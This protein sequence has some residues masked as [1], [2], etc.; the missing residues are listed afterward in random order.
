MFGRSVESRLRKVGDQIRAARREL[1]V[2]DE[3]IP[4]L[5][6]D[7][8]DAATRAVVS[9]DRSWGPEARRAGEHVDTYRRERQRLAARIVELE[10]R[11][12]E[13]LDRLGDTRRG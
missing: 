9:D 3:Q 7:A 11:Q 4:Y 13:L 5:D 12:D 6:D 10:R 1:A 2:L 8:S